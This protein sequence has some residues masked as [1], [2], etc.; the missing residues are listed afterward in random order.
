M[1][2]MKRIVLVIIGLWILSAIV[3]GKI[4]GKKVKKYYNT[5]KMIV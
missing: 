1:A 5:L 3:S 4:T 2:L